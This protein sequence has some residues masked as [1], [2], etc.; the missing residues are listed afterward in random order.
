MLTGYF[1][2][3]GSGNCGHRIGSPIGGFGPVEKFNG[4]SAPCRR[5]QLRALRAGGVS[6][7]GPTE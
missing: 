5:F 4:R 6:D 1:G 7:E 2:L 3:P